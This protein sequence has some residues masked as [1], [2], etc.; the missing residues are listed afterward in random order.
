MHD[1]EYKKKI[2]RHKRTKVS[3]V[4]GSVIAVIVTVGVL[5]ISNENRVYQQAE[6][7]NEIEIQ[8]VENRNWCNLGNYILSYTTDGANCRNEKGEVIWNRAYQLQTPQIDICGTT[9]AISEY[10]AT[11][12]YVMNTQKELAQIDTGMPVKDFCVSESGIVAAVL[13]DGATTWIYLYDTKGE[14]LVCFKTTIQDSGYPIKIDLSPNGMLLGVSFVTVQDAEIKTKIAF[15]NFGEV[16]QNK[17]DLLVSAYEYSGV[18]VPVIE[19]V[20]GDEIFALASN[21]LMVYAGSEIPSHKAETL[22]G[23]EIQGVIYSDEYIGLVSYGQTMESKYT[24]SVYNTKAELV[25]T[26][27][28]D[29]YYMDIVFD[30]NH[31]LIYSDTQMELYKVNGNL[32]YEMLFQEPVQKIL[33]TNKDNKFNVVYEDTIQTIELR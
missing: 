2:K 32:V 21:R 30:G 1:L 10:N 28:F 7:T 3:L 15:Y 26:I 23:R 31:I 13:E 24:L 9:V 33:L 6:V 27:P 25:G 4:I 14:E 20:K 22:I 12:I 11:S 16:G 17:S 5:Y 18:V 29:L 19:F 8:S